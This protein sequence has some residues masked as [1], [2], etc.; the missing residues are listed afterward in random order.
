MP[1]YCRARANAH[2]PSIPSHLWGSQSW[3]QPPFR[4]LLRLATPL[5]TFPPGSPSTSVNASY[6]VLPP[7]RF[8]QGSK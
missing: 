7:I 5:E 3:L 4:R 6:A 2:K 8:P 1:P